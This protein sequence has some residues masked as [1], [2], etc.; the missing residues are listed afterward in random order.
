VNSYQR[1]HDGAGNRKNEVR[2]EFGHVVILERPDYTTMLAGLSRNSY[3]VKR[4]ST[5]AEASAGV[6][7]A[8]G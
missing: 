1:T 2:Q 5:P 4:K 7:E 3:G 8:T 6:K